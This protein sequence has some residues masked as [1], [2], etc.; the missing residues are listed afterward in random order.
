MIDT[1]AS[2][3]T[4]QKEEYAC[5][6]C[7][8]SYAPTL[9]EMVDVTFT[10]SPR[11]R[12]IGGAFA[13]RTAAGRVLQADVLGFGRRSPRG[14]LRSSRRRLRHRPLELAPG[15][16][17]A[18]SILLPA[19]FVIVFEPVTHSAQFI[20]VKGEPTRE[21][22][23]LSISYDRDHTQNQTIEMQ[24]GPLRLALENR[25]ESARAAKRLHCG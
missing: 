12:R 19:E 2:L 15:E 8:D 21:R 6:L 17:G 3:K 11:V 1:N 25:T 4:V 7:A 18:L 20:D 23:N 13:G 16:K 5:A 24:P 22:Q 9:D 14:E 10:V